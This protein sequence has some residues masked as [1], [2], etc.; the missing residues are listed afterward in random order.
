MDGSPVIDLAVANCFARDKTGRLWIG[1]VDGGMWYLDE[2]TNK[3]ARLKPDNYKSESFHFNDMV[4]SITMDNAGTLWVGSDRGINIF[5]PSYQPFYTLSN[6]ELST[7]GIPASNLRQQFVYAFS[8]VFNKIIFTL[9]IHKIEKTIRLKFCCK[10]K[11][12]C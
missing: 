5:N 11:W 6:S 7:N 4:Y 10:I 2:R 9:S 12:F 3:F 1:S 8:M